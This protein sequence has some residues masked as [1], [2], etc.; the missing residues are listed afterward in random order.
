M[1]NLEIIV[2]SK[3]NKVGMKGFKSFSVDNFLNKI[4][5]K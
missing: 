5:K 4:R 3:S 2:W 1:K